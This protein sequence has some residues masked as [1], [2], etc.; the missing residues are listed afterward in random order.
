MCWSFCA[1][2]GAPVLRQSSHCESVRDSERASK[3]L[4]QTARRTHTRK[5]DAAC[6]V[7]LI[8]SVL[9]ATF[10]SP[11]TAQTISLGEAQNFSILGGSTVTNTGATSIV[12]N[13]G[14]S[15][16]SA[17]TG[18]P[19]GVVSNGAIHSNDALASQAH[20]DAFTAYNTLVG[21]VPTA[22][23]TGQDLGGMTLN[24]GVYHFDTSAQ[25]TGAL[26]LNTTGNPTGTFIFQI[27]STLTTASNSA[28]TFVG[29]A[30]PNIFWQV[31]SSATLGTNTPF[32]GNLL[33]FT[34][35]TLT[36]GANITVGR[37][38]AINGAV[39]MDT[40]FVNGTVAGNF[41]KGGASNLWSGVNWSPD[42]T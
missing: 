5:S 35:I 17:I 16:G 20:A 21:E 3:G 6:A 12:G 33:A 18:F 27:G 25:L 10:L 36:A 4:H 23:L 26:L 11:V 22:N 39:T 29:P 40:N 14:V 24:P 1:M 8:V 31:G 9:V 37:A 19:P 38:L 41:W 32:D 42:A 34:S 28:V 7:T 13:I 15:P 30:D 2:F